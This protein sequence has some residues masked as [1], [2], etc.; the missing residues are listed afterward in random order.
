MT[1]M[2]MMM[3][4]RKINITTE[5]FGGKKAELGNIEKTNSIILFTDSPL[6]MMLF[7]LRLMF[8]YNSEVFAQSFFF[9][10]IILDSAVA[11]KKTRHGDIFCMI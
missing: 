6:C 4:K 1:M 5:S 10:N 2:M 11:V 3:R 9:Y 8:A 7:Y